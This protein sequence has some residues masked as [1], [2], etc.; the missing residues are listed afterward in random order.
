[1]HSHTPTLKSFFITS[2]FPNFHHFFT[3]IFLLYP[4][5]LIFLDVL[6]FCLLLC[7]LHAMWVVLSEIHT[8]VYVLYFAMQGGS[9]TLTAALQW[10]KQFGCGGHFLPLLKNN[11]KA[12]HLPLQKLSLIFQNLQKQKHL[13]Q[14]YMS[15]N[16]GSRRPYWICPKLVCSHWK[17]HK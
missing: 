10:P 14:K 15:D 6:P 1:M 4:C 2:L 9:G 12:K 17:H 16:K 13:S 5:H 7:G 8:A 3:A 11:R